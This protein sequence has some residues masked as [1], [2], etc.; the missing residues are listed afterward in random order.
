MTAKTERRLKITPGE[1]KV[2]KNLFGNRY[3][4]AIY[5]NGPT[6]KDY[7]SIAE[8]YGVDQ[9]PDAALYADAHNTANACDMLPSEILAKLREA[10]KLLGYFTEGWSDEDGKSYVDYDDA[11]DAEVFISTLNLPDP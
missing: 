10:V 4:F 5:S 9:E 7:L 2:S 1:A 8:L 6:G 11:E 3:Q